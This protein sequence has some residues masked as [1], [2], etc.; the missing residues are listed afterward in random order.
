MKGQ[1]GCHSNCAVS[2]AYR[3]SGMG[4]RPDVNQPAAKPRLG[5]QNPDW[6][7]GSPL[8]LSSELR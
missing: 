5:L 6:G 4:G 8:S 7:I 3:Q 1:R 2:P